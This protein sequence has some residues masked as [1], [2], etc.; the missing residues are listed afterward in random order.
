MIKSSRIILSIILSQNVNSSRKRCQRS[1]VLRWRM[2]WKLMN[3]YKKG[4]SDISR[5]K[6]WVSKKMTIRERKE[7]ST[8]TGH[9]LPWMRK[10]PN[11]LIDSIHV[12]KTIPSVLCSLSLCTKYVLRML[13]DFVKHSSVW[14]LNEVLGGQR[15]FNHDEVTTASY[16]W[17]QKQSR[18]FYDVGIN[19]LI[20]K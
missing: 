15:F 6:I 9:L 13:T 19:V 5:V 18:S 16:T 11:R 4:S 20:Q 12:K 14:S 7:N 2:G 3:V 10:K 17:Q 1:S 8:V